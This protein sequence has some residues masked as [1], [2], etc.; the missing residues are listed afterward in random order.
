MIVKAENINSAMDA[1]FR[2][3]ACF[4]HMKKKNR[5]RALDLDA[6]RT[7]IQSNAMGY[8]T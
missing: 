4:N 8:P 5:L 1:A 7:K 2:S 3:K 6:G